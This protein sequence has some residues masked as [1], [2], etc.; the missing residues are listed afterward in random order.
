MHPKDD[1]VSEARQITS[2][3]RRV[4]KQLEANVIQINSVT[5]ALSHDGELIKETLDEHAYSLKGALHSTKKR[6]NLLKMAEVWERYSVI[7]SVIFFTTVVLY[8]IIKRTRIMKLLWILLSS[9]I[10]GGNN[11]SR[12][13]FKDNNITN[14]IMI[15]TS[16]PIQKIVEYDYR[17]LTHNEKD[18]NNEL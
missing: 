18:V 9:I 17:N 3:L 12:I 8:I 1:A 14:E 16:T 10:Y 13:F 11:I 2:S 5:A 4:K 6:L 7:G 15:K